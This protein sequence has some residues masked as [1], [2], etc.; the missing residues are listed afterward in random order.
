[1]PLSPARTITS[2]PRS[3]STS[4]RLPVSAGAGGADVTTLPTASVFTAAGEIVGR[5][6]VA[7]VVEQQKRIVVTGVAEPKGPAELHTR[8]FDGGP[9]L[10]DALDGSDGHG[11]DLERSS[12][13]AY[14]AVRLV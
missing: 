7:E 14:V 4:D 9:R 3:N 13:V 2:S 10:D 8:A 6:V 1:M 11:G 12:R 5:A